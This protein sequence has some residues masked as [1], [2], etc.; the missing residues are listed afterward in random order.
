ML[1]KKVADASA[2]LDPKAKAWEQVDREVIDLVGT[3]IHRQTSRYVRTVWADRLIGRV[4]AVAVRAAHDGQRLAIQLEWNDETENNDYGNRQFPD[5]AAVLFPSNGDAP[6]GTMGSPDA[7]V[8]GWFWRA[9]LSE[10]Q[11]IVAQGPGTVEKANGATIDAKGV[12]K[13]GRWSVV[14]S[15]TLSARGKDNV[16]LAPGKAAK[17]AFAVWEGSN[18]ERGGLKAYSRDWREITLE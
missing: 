1:A 13:D 5:A 11:N 16:K 7:H 4:R 15:R 17:I 10:G 18:Q 14:L 6:L 9:D 3:P 2:L 8:N 12:W